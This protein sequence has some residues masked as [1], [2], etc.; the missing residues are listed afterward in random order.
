MKVILR[1]PNEEDILAIEK[2]FNGPWEKHFSFLH[3]FES[4]ADS[5]FEKYISILPKLSDISFL[6]VGHV[7]C[8][9]L[10]A[11]NEQNEVIGRVSIR[12]ELNETL[13]K[14][15]GHIGY[16]VVPSHRRKGYATQILA[17]S[18]KYVRRYLPD[19]HEILVT[20]DDDNIGSIKTI[21]N[22]HG[23]LIDKYIDESLKVSKRRYL[24]N[25]PL[26]RKAI[27]EDAYGIHLAHMKS[28]QEVCSKDHSIE[29]IN[30]WGNRPYNEEQ[31]LQ[32]IKNELV[33][34]AEYQDNI[35]GYGHL[36][37]YEKNETQKGHVH[38]LYLSPKII[39]LGCGKEILDKMVYEGIKAGI[40][41]ITLESTLT[42]YRFYKE[43]GFHDLG[44]QKTLLI[45][46]Q[47][48]RCYLME[49]KL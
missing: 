11:F 3:Y 6:P 23:K 18:L 30:A 7:P 2:A 40:S 19:L 35:E 1:G 29:E 8:T 46:G 48:V 41:S 37:F 15:G 32:A 43:M 17:E 33:W 47:Q 31:R 25:L 27:P 44:G 4:L 45:N 21:E 38:G 10:F 22:N 36:K 34:V 49:M 28:I 14:V 5:S 16:G 13:S 42:A 39:G 9:F 12:H 26:I 20:C 24:I